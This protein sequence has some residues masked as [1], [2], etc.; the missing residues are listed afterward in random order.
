MAVPAA[1]RRRGTLVRYFRDLPE[2]RSGGL[3]LRLTP[4]KVHDDSYEGLSKAV[5]WLDETGT[6]DSVLLLRRGN[7]VSHI[8]EGGISGTGV[9]LTEAFARE[10]A[11]PLTS[12]ERSVAAEDLKM[13]E[14]IPEAREHIGQ[15]KA[16]LE[17]LLSE[18]DPEARGLPPLLPLRFE[19]FPGEDD[20]T[21]RRVKLTVDKN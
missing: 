11:R 9:S 8:H 2:A 7:L 5:E 17:P 18:T 21:V 1:L 19:E 20:I 12:T 10:R 14:S 16:L 3:P 4:G 15:I 13:L 6:A